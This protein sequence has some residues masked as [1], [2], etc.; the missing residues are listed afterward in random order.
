MLGVQTQLLQ[1]AYARLPVWHDHGL[2]SPGW[3]LCAS[4]HA[5]TS[6]TTALAATHSWLTLDIAI[7]IGFTLQT[8]VTALHFFW[9]IGNRHHI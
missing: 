7:G 3:W 4:A 6:S 9:D 2:G 1:P 8:I 5:Q